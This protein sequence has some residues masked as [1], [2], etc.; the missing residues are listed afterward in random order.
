M[1][2]IDWQMNAVASLLHSLFQINS[3]VNLRTA[4]LRV[5]SAC[6]GVMAAVTL[7]GHTLELKSYN[8]SKWQLHVK[9]YLH[10]A[11]M[12]AIKKVGAGVCVKSDLNHG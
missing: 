7:K 10:K 11:D 8:A 2:D 12:H 4:W 3:S 5:S 1:S 9:C 6:R